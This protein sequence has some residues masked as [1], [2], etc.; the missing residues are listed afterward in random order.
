MMK[1]LIVYI[2]FFHAYFIYGQNSSS[3]L[4]NAE[5][6]TINQRILTPEGY[7]RTLIKEGSFGSYLRT[8]KLKP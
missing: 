2:L 7:K 6:Q 3:A 8:L 4:I 5:G 1:F